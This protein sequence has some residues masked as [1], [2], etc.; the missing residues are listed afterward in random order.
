RALSFT[1]SA[2]LQPRRLSVLY[3]YS[4]EQAESSNIENIVRQT[5][6]ESSGLK[7]D[8]TMFSATA[9]DAST[10]AGLLF[11][12]APLAPT[13]LSGQMTPAQAAASDIGNLFSALA[14]EGAGKTAV[15][16][17][18]P[19]Q[20]KR[21][22]FVAGPKFSTE[23]ITSTVLPAGVVIALE[24]AS[25]VSGFSAVPTFRVNDVTT[26]HA[27]DTSPT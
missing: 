27:E 11:G 14:T 7:L 9:G 21:L 23:I 13:A 6:G 26:Y 12:I 1:N 17:A 24:I 2:I 16:V 15:L 19:P 3:A 18:S 25:F 8:A 5:L 10:P 22:E 4:R 20:A